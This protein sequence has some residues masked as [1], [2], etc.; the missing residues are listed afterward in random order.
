MG[1]WFGR[2]SCG[3]P[4]GQQGYGG[5]DECYG[6]KYEGA[7]HDDRH[8]EEM[9]VSFRDVDTLEV[10]RSLVMLSPGPI[11][12]KAATAVKMPVFCCQM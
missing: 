1:I 7:A 5:K 9:E 12:S 8:T 10:P 11:A 4:Q 2:T 3:Q 6:S